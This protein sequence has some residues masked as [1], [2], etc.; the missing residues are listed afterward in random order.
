M[1]KFYANAVN[2][3]L[4]IFGFAITLCLGLFAEIVLHKVIIAVLLPFSRRICS[5]NFGH[6]HLIPTETANIL[7]L[8]F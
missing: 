3:H 7:K 6:K 8:Q 5:V 1:R 2:R 4:V